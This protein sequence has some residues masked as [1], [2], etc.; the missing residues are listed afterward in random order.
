LQGIFFNLSAKRLNCPIPPLSRVDIDAMGQD[1]WPGN[2]CELQNMIERAV[3][4]SRSRFGF[5][6]PDL[7]A[8]DRFAS[9]PSN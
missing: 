1:A 8:R 9:T 4:V 3:I 5:H 2:M 7:L 6:L